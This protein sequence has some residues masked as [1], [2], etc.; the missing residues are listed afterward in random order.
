MDV[1]ILLSNNQL[2]IFNDCAYKWHL[3][4]VEG[5]KP[6]NKRVGAAAGRGI[7]LHELLDVFYK[8][9]KSNDPT[10]AVKHKAKQMLQGL[11][12][13]QLPLFNHVLTLTLR[14]IEDYA[15]TA[16]KYLDV[17]DTERHFQIPL[18][19]P[20]GVKYQL[21]GYIDAI[22]FD[23]LQQ[24]TY[25]LDHKSVGNKKSFW[26]ER[27]ILMDPQL[28]MYAAALRVLGYEIHGI[29]LNFINA[30]E[31]K[32]PRPPSDLFHREYDV[33]S[34]AHID[35]VLDEVGRAVDEMADPRP[36]RK[37]LSKNCAYCD[38]QRV[39]EMELKGITPLPYLKQNFDKEK[40]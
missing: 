7:W 3:G 28:P 18:E 5:W 9:R 37:S 32:S 21:Q 20:N 16:D 25:V 34:P 4:Y 14:Y 22:V 10:I 11:T 31:Y 38:F 2:N 26:S 33:R 40:K 27:Q 19:S 24:Q 39:C 1:D 36:K 29:I 12:Q 35:S 23:T 30:Y 15:P 6:K 17:I 13:E 8:N